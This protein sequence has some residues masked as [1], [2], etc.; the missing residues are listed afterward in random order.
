MNLHFI[1]LRRKY[2]IR[3]KLEKKYNIQNLKFQ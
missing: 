2:N 1:N 3:I